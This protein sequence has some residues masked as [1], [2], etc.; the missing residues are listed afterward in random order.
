MGEKLTPEM[1]GVED[2]RVKYINHPENLGERK[3]LNSLLECAGGRFFTWQFDDDYYASDYTKKI[4]NIIA[5]HPDLNCVF[6][7][8]KK[9]FSEELDSSGIDQEDDDGMVLSGRV[10]LRSYWKRKI[11]AMGFTAAFRT[12]YLQALGGVMALSSG[13]YAL[14]SEYV[15]L[16]NAAKEDA[17]GYVKS[18]QVYYYVH[19]ASWSNVNSELSLYEESG[20]NLLRESQKIFQD[21]ALVQ[22]IDYNMAHVVKLVFHEYA[23]KVS[24]KSGLT[25]MKDLRDFF[26]RDLVQYFVRERRITF[27]LRMK[28][29]LI[30]WK[31]SIVPI[32]KTKTKKIVHGNALI[33]LLKVHAEFQ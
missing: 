26:D 4:I 24:L 11:R 1:V 6:T 30:R 3:N 7:S 14:F 31:W 27:L 2:P 29:L 17:V 23:K 13:P 12:N 10:F 5:R 19:N 32:L 18:P 25:F 20:I 33:R 8:Y 16:F 15:L 22:D 28:L 9:V 21:R